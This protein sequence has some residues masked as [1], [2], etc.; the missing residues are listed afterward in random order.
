MNFKGFLIGVYAFFS[1][2]IGM[3]CMYLFKNKIPQIRR[4]WAKSMVKLIG[5]KIEELGRFDEN[6][7]IL[8]LNH[9]SMLDIIIL[10]YLYPKEIAWVANVKL[11]NTPLFGWVFK[12]PNLILIDPQKRSSFKTLISRVREEIADKRPVGIFPEGTRGENDDIINFQKGTKLIV[13]K[14][15]LTVQPIVLINT[16]KRL[17]TKTFQSTPGRVKVICLDTVKPSESNKNWFEEMEQSVREVY[18]QNSNLDC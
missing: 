13:E 15:N 5:I 8:I 9:N 12:L 14:L 1:L 4:F 10:D 3:I 6:A 18:K 17:D 2:L 16:R 11:A 7:D